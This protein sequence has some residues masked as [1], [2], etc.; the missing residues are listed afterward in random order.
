MATVPKPNELTHLDDAELARLAVIWRARAGHG[1]R[2]AFGIAHALEV[3]RRRRLRESQLQELPAEPEPERRWWQFWRSRVQSSQL[4]QSP[5][6]SVP[7]GSAQ[8]AGDLPLN[9]K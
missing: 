6:S 9:R 8:A 1:Q 3:E 2:E 7:A 4:S 5:Q